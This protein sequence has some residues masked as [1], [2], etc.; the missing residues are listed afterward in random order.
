ML[1]NEADALDATQDALLAAVRAIERFDGRSS[2]ST[3][4]Y[5]ISTNACIDEL[6]RRR[7]SPL[8][9]LPPE[10]AHDTTSR[11]S[12][13][14]AG[15]NLLR[16]GNQSES[17]EHPPEAWSARRRAGALARRSEDPAESVATRADIDAALGTL[18][19]EFRTA[20]VLRDLCD[21]AYD[22]IAEIL[23]VPVGTV[24]SRIARGRAAL[25]V[26][27]GQS[28]WRVPGHTSDQPV[29]DGSLRGTLDA[30]GGPSGA[31]D[32]G[33]TVRSG[34]NRSGTGHVKST[35]EQMS[36]L[37]KGANDP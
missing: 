33:N 11:R 22:E 2:F 21:L 4:L 32:P 25:A 3:W 15:R 29:E 20:V 30:R 27:L 14:G 24:R 7:R 37:T 9:G 28:M 16:H 17:S 8:V 34:G 5:R 23:D 6:R 10:E 19:M 31:E 12:R 13:V 36:D 35:S 1:G 26:C 18:A